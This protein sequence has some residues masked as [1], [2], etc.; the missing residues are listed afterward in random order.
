MCRRTQRVPVGLAV[1]YMLSGLDELGSSRPH[2]LDDWYE[3]VRE[4]RNRHRDANG[5]VF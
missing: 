3:P 4:M 5:W 1:E 2:P